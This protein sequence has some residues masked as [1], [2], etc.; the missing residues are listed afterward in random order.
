MFV[1]RLGPLTHDVYY[2]YHEEKF[3]IGDMIDS[4]LSRYIRLYVKS[5]FNSQK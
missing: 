1:H 5:I 3:G 4:Y 2:V